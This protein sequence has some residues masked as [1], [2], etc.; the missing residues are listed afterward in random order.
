MLTS[1]TDRGVNK[2]PYTLHDA[3][4]TV[5]NGG[6]EIRTYTSRNIGGVVVSPGQVF[7]LTAAQA[8]ALGALV[9]P[10]TNN[11]LASYAN[12]VTTNA[13][14]YLDSTGGSN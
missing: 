12:V 9:D 14:C 10:V 6:G 11:A 13:A 2:L 5:V 7:W 4:Y 1:I 3:N 8:L